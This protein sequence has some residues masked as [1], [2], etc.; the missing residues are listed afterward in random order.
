MKGGGL[1]PCEATCTPK[2]VRGHGPPENLD[3]AFNFLQSGS[4]TDATVDRCARQR[5]LRMSRYEIILTFTCSV[6]RSHVVWSYI[7]SRTPG[8]NSVYG[9]CHSSGSFCLRGGWATAPEAHPPVSAPECV[10]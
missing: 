3:Y 8:Q 2:G 6:A 9:A 5:G 10:T 1:V 7:H 4:K